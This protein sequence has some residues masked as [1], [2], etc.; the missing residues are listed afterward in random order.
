MWFDKFEDYLVLDG[1]RIPTTPPK[2]FDKELPKVEKVGDY[3]PVTMEENNNIF[4]EILEGNNRIRRIDD[5]K[6]SYL[7]RNYNVCG[8]CKIVVEIEG[9]PF[10]KCT[11]CNKEMCALCWSERTEEIALQNGAKNWHK[12]KDDLEHCFSHEDKFIVWRELAVFCDNCNTESHLSPGVWMCDREN[13]I[14]FCPDCHDKA[15]KTAKETYYRSETEEM[16]FG[17]LLDWIYVLRDQDGN[18]V[19]YNI[20]KDS[21]K[22]HTIALLNIDGH[23]REG[24]F[25]MNY[26]LEDIVERLR[27]NDIPSILESLDLEIDYG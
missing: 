19:L 3:F 27:E 20:N 11:E 6:F 26:S 1:S 24:Y 18:S 21:P 23:G 8:Y 12:R 22:Y 15:P 2:N 13:D 5:R 25:T 17:S 14:D 9:Y 7:D 16:A 10:R 4:E